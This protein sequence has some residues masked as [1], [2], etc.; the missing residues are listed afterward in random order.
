MKDARRNRSKYSGGSDKNLAS[1][2]GVRNGEQYNL[3]DVRADNS[4]FSSGNESGSETNVPTRGI[5][6]SISFSIEVDN[7]LKIKEPSHPGEEV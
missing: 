3:S 1:S 7:A 4:A 5:M 2:Q 6:K